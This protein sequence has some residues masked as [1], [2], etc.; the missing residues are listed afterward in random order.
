MYLLAR[1][2]RT[3]LLAFLVSFTLIAPA[4]L[5]QG[6]ST[7]AGVVG[8]VADE[9]GNVIAGA[10]VKATNTA[11]NTVREITTDETGNYSLSQLPPGNYELIVALE[12]FTTQTLRVDLILGSTSRVDFGLK[13]GV[14]S[15][16]V[17]VTATNIIEEAKTESSNNIDRQRIES[18]PINRRNFLDFSL[19]SP[20]VT[21]DRVPAQ[22]AAATSGLSFNGQNGRV[23]NVTVDGLDNN[24][25]GTGSVRATFSQEAIQEFQ[26]VSD[27]Y[28][29]EFGRALGGVVNI[30]TKGGSN[31]IHGS[32]FFLTRNDATSA[33]DVFAPTEP[34][35]R[36]YQFGGTISG[37]IKKDKAF[38]F[39]SFERLSIKQNNFVTISDQTVASAN[40][41]GFGI[42]NGPIPF[43]LGTTSILTRTDVQL[44]QS[45]RLF[46]RYNFGGNFN[47]AFE[48]FGALVAQSN[49]SVQ[50][51]DENTLAVNNTY[52]RNTLVNETRFIY[53]RRNQDVD[54]VNPGPQVRVF[55]PEGQVIL[56]RSTFSPQ[57]RELRVYQFVNNTSIISGRHS[58]KFGV[59]F[60]RT[61]TPN[62]K[63]EVPVF[64][65]GL[66]IFF[67]IDF[68]ALT[69][70]PGLPSFSGLEAFDPAVRSPLQRAF[71][72]VL[73]TQL[74]ILV[75]GFP[76]NVPLV[77]LPLPSSYIQ[78]FGDPRI[79]IDLNAFSGFIQDDIKLKPN[80]TLKLGARYDITRVR[81]V[82][83]NNG[84]VSPR[85]AFAYRPGKL[86]KL[87]VRGAYGLFFAAPVT[88]PS[89]IT[90]R[91]ATNQLNQLL[92][93]FP[94]AI[95]PFAQPGRRFP[96][97]VNVP[98][99]VQF[100]PQLSQS[101][102]Y[103]DDTVNGYT[104]QASFGLDYLVG[105]N[106]VVSASYQYVRGVKLL[107]QRDINPVVRPTGNPVESALI[108]RVD[109]T[110]GTIFEFSSS[111]DSYFHGLTLTLNRRFA[112]NFSLFANYT[113]SKGIDNFIDLRPDLNEVQNPLTPRLERGLSLQDVRH[114]FVVSGTL[115]FAIFQ[116]PF[117]K[118]F[119]LSS[120]TT[121]NTGRPYNL[122]AGADLD[123]NGDQP[124]G[125][126][127]FGIGRNTGV[128]PGFGNVDMRLTR[129]FVINDRVR[130][131]GIAELF[132]V[133]NRVNI[134]EIDRV[135]A[136]GTALPN[137]DDE[138][139]F[140]A[141]KE[142]FR[143]AFSPR[144][145]QFGFR[146]TF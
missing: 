2:L 144:Q 14:T 111:F 98:A 118:G 32:L 103:A 20:R 56:G 11:T 10:T 124:P 78:G 65:G 100:T 125:D 79:E 23:N 17:E 85:V 22:G 95:F 139:R 25:F 50:N 121:L 75:P 1:F 68:S 105:N 41:L 35:Y 39:G 51:L 133:F 107:S 62:L 30:V 123:Q 53:S 132:N 69:G 108:G 34:E 145:F 64:G 113:F 77:N 120:I 126:R 86:D 28:S 104:Q 36:Q 61:N 12:G 19:T 114:R 117:L 4:V 67:P 29:A 43:G 110:R 55:A 109:P 3:G 26:V 38:F 93:P 127:P 141:P 18:L 49:A 66:A 24:D 8:T 142:R 92:I 60:N 84:N 130:I 80:F 143:N 63:T 138:G 48:P 16:I 71:L 76:A 73:S 15:D 57:P 119:Q 27:S 129:T 9:Q 40:N 94:G 122:L 135:F 33:R 13:V 74:P 44:G 82:P 7:T 96:D 89:F 106:T 102:T 88:G 97:S 54:P 131:Q 90:G 42:S 137:R 81:F 83:D 58:I 46:V 45:D 116:A 140:V 31:D 70:I 128:A 6:G 101:F 99:G 52:V 21:A 5:A 112:N 59:D 91:T 115:D 134:S 72:T 87:T 136:P 146:M 37:P 47:G